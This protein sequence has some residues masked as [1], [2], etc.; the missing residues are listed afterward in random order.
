MCC[1]LDSR[2]VTRCGLLWEEDLVYD[3]DD[4]VLGLDVRLGDEGVVDA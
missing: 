4:A 2:P 1:P 3:V